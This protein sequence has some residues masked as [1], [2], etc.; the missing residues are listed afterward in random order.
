MGKSGKAI[1]ILTFILGLTSC[2]PSQEQV[3]KA[4]VAEMARRDDEKA[5]MFKYIDEY[6]AT[7]NQG[8]RQPP[9]QPQ[10]NN[11][12]SIDE[13]LKN[14]KKIEIGMSPVRGYR[15]AKVT[16]VEFSDFQCPF[17]SQVVPT[18]NS[19]LK[20]YDG[21]IKIVY[22]NQ[23][24]PFHSYAKGAAQAALAA[25]KQGKFWEMHDLLF[26]N[27]DK[28]DRESITGFAKKLGLNESKFK[29]DLDDPANIKRIEEEASWAQANGLG[30]TPSF[31]IN[32]VTLVGAQREEKFS[33]VID[34]ALKITN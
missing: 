15:N 34:R 30:G 31:L 32:G 12:P 7:K 14:P 23:P 13:S 21:K 5:R 1:F 22:K 17:C 20:K 10:A 2:S 28:L 6:V 25:Q 24:L 29:Q 9:Q 16:I 19:L 18:L 27:Q 8:L 3:D 4:V 26:S 11:A 33:D